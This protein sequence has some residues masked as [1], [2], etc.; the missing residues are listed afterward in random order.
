[1]PGVGPAEAGTMV[2]TGPVTEQRQVCRYIFFFFFRDF[3]I[4]FIG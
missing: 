4:P 2:A 1:M 3:K